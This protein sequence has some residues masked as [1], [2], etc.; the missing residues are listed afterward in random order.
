MQ[1]ENSIWTPFPVRQDIYSIK[2]FYD[3]GNK[4]Q[5]N[6]DREIDNYPDLFGNLCV[7]YRSLPEQNLFAEP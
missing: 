4:S 6:L 7:F 5:G 1:I 2:F 3:V